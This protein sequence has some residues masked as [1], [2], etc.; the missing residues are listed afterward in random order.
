MTEEIN[1]KHQIS[2][3]FEFDSQTGTVRII[4]FA[5]TFE[6]NVDPP[7][8]QANTQIIDQQTEQVNQTQQ[9]DQTEQV[10]QVEQN[11]NTQEIIEQLRTENSLFKKIHELLPK[12][13]VSQKLCEV[14]GKNGGDIKFV[15]FLLKLGADPYYGES[16]TQTPLY[17]ALKNE[18]YDVAELLIKNYVDVNKIIGNEPIIFDLIRNN[19]IKQLKFLLKFGLD[20]DISSKWYPYNVP[21][22]WAAYY[23]HMSIVEFLVT[24]RANINKCSGINQSPLYIAADKQHYK[25]AEYL[26]KNGANVNIEQSS[27]VPSKRTPTA[28]YIASYNEDEEMT[29]LLLENGAEYKYILETKH[30]QFIESVKEKLDEEK[31]KYVETQIVQMEKSTSANAEIEQKT[32]EPAATENKSSSLPVDQYIKTVIPINGKSFPY[33]GKISDISEFI[34]TMRSVTY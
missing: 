22:G 5:S 26:I 33:E 25:I 7:T 27:D 12:T 34:K 19:H 28:I 23:G 13:F 32:S 20:L 6:K 17:C 4:N 15:E 16:R 2:I 9:V 11:P 21:V 31:K 24:N 14:I 29:K 3:N 18:W 10:E 8:D 30:R 1:G